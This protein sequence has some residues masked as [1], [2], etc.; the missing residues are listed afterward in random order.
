MLNALF[1]AIMQQFVQNGFTVSVR[2]EAPMQIVPPTLP[3]VSNAPTTQQSINQVLPSIQ[4][5]AVAPI[6]ARAI[7]PSPRSGRNQKSRSNADKAKDGAA[8]GGDK[9]GHAVNISV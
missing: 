2:S 6:A 5:Q 3:I 8:P 9:R 7:D 1:I 4:A